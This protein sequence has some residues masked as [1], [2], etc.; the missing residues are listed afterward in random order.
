MKTSLYCS[1]WWKLYQS[2][3]PFTENQCLHLLLKSWSWK[4]FKLRGLLTRHTTPTPTMWGVSATVT[5]KT[6]SS[7][8]TFGPGS[9]KIKLINGWIHGPQRMKPFCGW[10]LP[11][12][13]PTARIVCILYITT[14]PNLFEQRVS[15][16]TDFC[17]NV[18]V[19]LRIYP[20]I[21]YFYCRRYLMLQ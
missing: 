11:N 19:C 6:T 2:C 7:L 8:F 17:S 21:Q 16:I 13:F 20:K 12:L 4:E 10:W 9:S 18:Y 3:T 15:N 14:F 5:A 1:T